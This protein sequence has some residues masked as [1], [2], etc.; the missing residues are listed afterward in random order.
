[1]N[2]RNRIEGLLKRAARAGSAGLPL[3]AATGA[4]A[5]LAAYGLEPGRQ[6]CAQGLGMPAMR[7]MPSPSR[8]F[9]P[10]SRPYTPPARPYTPPPRPYTPPARPYTPPARPY[11]PPPSFE[12][13]GKLQKSIEGYTDKVTQK[14]QR[15]YRPG[16]PGP[17]IID[18][19]R[20]IILQDPEP[21][22]PQPK[23][24]APLFRFSTG[25]T[26]ATTA[27]A[28]LKRGTTPLLMVDTG[29]QLRVTGVRGDWVGLH[30]WQN[31][32]RYSGW[33]HRKYL[34]PVA[35]AVPAA[36][37]ESVPAAPGATVAEPTRYA[38]VTCDN[39][40][41]FEITYTFIWDD[42]EPET[43]TLQPSE[44]AF[45]SYTYEGL[46]AASPPVMHITFDVDGSPE[47]DLHSRVLDARIASSRD[48]QSSAVYRFVGDGQGTRI[49]LE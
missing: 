33:I 12:F 24:A 4:L 45:H 47:I 49:V 30:V 31:G 23:P 42:E 34:K 21:T 8:T 3:L 46:N 22:W 38:L 28:P 17:I 10:P 16:M 32:Q 29:T 18:D 2:C 39:L 19:L 7:S 1:M 41:S 35:P 48:E 40:T 36:F 14:G 20:P 44:G 13:Q 11:T 43:Y 25:D 5:L 37:W 15:P 26:V 9:T 6:A 27:R